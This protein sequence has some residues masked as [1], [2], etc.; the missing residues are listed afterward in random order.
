MFDFTITI[1]SV[2][3]T[4]TQQV[5][6][7]TINKLIA[8][9]K[10][11]FDPVDVCFQDKL[12]AMAEWFSPNKGKIKNVTQHWDENIAPVSGTNLIISTRALTMNNILLINRYLKK[13]VKHG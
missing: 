13:D 2:D 12:D 10:S 9:I 6:T 4:K 7:E 8:K 1:R 3:N 5:K 11:Q